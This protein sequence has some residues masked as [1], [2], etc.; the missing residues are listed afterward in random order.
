MTAMI[1]LDE[2]TAEAETRI[3]VCLERRSRNLDLSDMGLIVVP[4]A[5]KELKP[6]RIIC[7]NTGR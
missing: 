3:Q 6:A 5:I 7:F 2:N 1:K 4:E